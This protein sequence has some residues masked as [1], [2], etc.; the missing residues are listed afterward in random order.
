MKTQT[1]TKRSRLLIILSSVAL[2]LILLAAV[3]LTYFI[4]KERY[5]RREADL[6][7][8]ASE[9]LESLKASYE[10]ERESTLFD[11]EI[12]LQVDEIARENALTPP[13]KE[14]LTEALVKAYAEAF[15]DKNTLY[16]TAEKYLSVTE[17]KNGA[18]VGIGVSVRALNEGDATNGELLVLSVFRDSPA[19]EVGILPGDVLTHANGVSFEGITAAEAAKLVKGEAGTLVTLS[20]LRGNETLSIT[21]ERREVTETCVSYRMTDDGIAYIRLTDFTRATASQFQEALEETRDATGIVFDLRGNPGGYVTS[22]VDCLSTLLPDGPMLHVNYRKESRSYHYE[23][24]NASLLYVHADGTYDI[25]K[26]ECDAS[27][28]LTR[29]C[30]VLIDR[31]TASA[32]EAFAAALRDYA[33]KGMINARLFGETSYG[34]GSI[35]I[36]YKLKNGS[37]F[38]VT[39]AKYDPPYGSNYHGVGVMPDELVPLPSAYEGALPET[40]PSELDAPLAAAQNWLLSQAK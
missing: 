19:E 40:V 3:F 2:S 26:T 27:A 31:H 4:T 25:K 17:E 1:K 23:K 13:E 12:L 24:K 7:R 21:A 11:L 34:K 14:A 36:T 29:P 6:R 39:V 15:G 37:A 38:R 33:G 22:L 18:F 9:A 32:G 30:A 5:G 10:T 16:Y 8:E 20:V 28:V 35:Q